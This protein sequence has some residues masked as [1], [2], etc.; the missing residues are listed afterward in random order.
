MGVRDLHKALVDACKETTFTQ[1]TQDHYAVT[2]RPFILGIDASIWFYQFQESSSKFKKHQSTMNPELRQAFKRLAFFLRLLIVLV[3][4]FDGPEHPS[5]KR[6]KKVIKRDHWM[7]I[8]FKEMVVAFG[9]H[10]HQAPGEAEAEL[11]F[12][13]TEGHIDAIL[14]EDSDVFVFGAKY[15]IRS[16]NPSKDPDAIAT[17]QSCDTDK[18]MMKG[19]LYLFAIL[20]GGDYHTGLKGCGLEL[21]RRLTGTDLSTD[22]RLL[23]EDDVSVWQAYL[24]HWRTKLQTQLA[25]DPHEL[26]GRKHKVLAASVPDA[27]PPLDVLRNYFQPVM[28][29]NLGSTER[30]RVFNLP[31][32]VNLGSVAEWLFNWKTLG[33]MDIQIRKYGIAEGYC[34]RQLLMHPDTP[35]LVTG[36]RKYADS[37]WF[38]VQFDASIFNKL[39]GSSHSATTVLKIP[40]SHLQPVPSVILAYLE[41]IRNMEPGSERRKKLDGS[42]MKTDKKADKKGNKKPV[43][44]PKSRK[45]GENENGEEA[46]LR[47]FQGMH[48]D[49]EASRK[50]A[51]NSEET[52][53]GYAG[54][55]K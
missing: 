51:N 54:F 44:K 48:A 47:G 50:K 30:W 22:L 28:S 52:T 21:A 45:G 36:V 34:V 26:L 33:T 25:S 4:V 19:G 10:F 5:T 20:R 7:A 24:P 41:E 40:A 9:Y 29:Q 46:R 43:K 23:S 42:T 8:S 15:T 16:L 1:I 6:G 12:L 49:A 35:T 27:F 31:M 13:N 2:R 18:I 53:K 55:R 17:Y 32:L 39:D 11:A 38:L 37:Y 3:F 14:T